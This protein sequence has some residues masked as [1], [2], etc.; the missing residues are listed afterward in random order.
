MS[1]D[2]S[3]CLGRESWAPG[4]HLPRR[5]GRVFRGLGFRGLG[6]WGLGFRDLGFRVRDLRF[7]VQGLGFSV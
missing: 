1:G 6:I 4:M 5:L 3:H 7:R 2:M